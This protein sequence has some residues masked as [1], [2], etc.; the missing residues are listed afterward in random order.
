M[1][2]GEFSA[3]AGGNP[4]MDLHPIRGR[5]RNT[6]RRFTLRKSEVSATQ[7]N[8]H[9]KKGNIIFTL[10]MI[11]YA[12]FLMCPCIDIKKVIDIKRI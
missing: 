4:E 3:G 7:K 11:S 10:T 8:K 12:Y 2:T 5:S 1:G 9:T 6:L